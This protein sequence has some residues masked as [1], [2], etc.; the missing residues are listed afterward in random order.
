MY[1]KGEGQKTQQQKEEVMS[2]LDWKQMQMM[3]ESRL[4]SKTFP[5]R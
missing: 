3:Q 5:I 2:G 4:G 1:V